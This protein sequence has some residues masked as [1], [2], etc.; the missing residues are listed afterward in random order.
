VI[1]IQDVHRNT[2]AQW[3]IRETVSA[4][5][6]TGQVSFLALE[7]AT[8]QIALQPY[9]DFPHPD[10]V[11]LAADYL[12]RENDI[13]GPIHAALTAQQ[14]LPPVLG[15]DDPTL[16]TAN[17]QAYR[18]SA[19]RLDQSRGQ[20]KKLQ[21]ELDERKKNVYSPAL[22]TF[23][24]S[25][26]DY[27]NGRIGLGPYVQSLMTATKA[28]APAAKTFLQALALERALDFH[29]V[30]I[31]RVRLVTVLTQRL[32]P[33]ETNALLADSLAYRAGRLGYADFYARLKNICRQADLK[34]SAYPAM[35]AYIRYVLLADGIDA[36]RLLNELNDLEKAAFTQLSRR[37]E[38]RILVNQSRQ[39]WLSQQLVNFS[40]TP[41]GWAEYET[42]PTADRNPQWASFESFYRAAHKRDEAM[43]HR[44]IAELQRSTHRSVA[45]LVTGGYHADGIAQ[46]LNRQGI[47]VVSFVPKI[48]KI[49]SQDG[50]T[51]LS[52]FTQAKTPLEKLFQGE[53][54]FLAQSPWKTS[55]RQ[56]LAPA[57]VVL[58]VGLVAS[59]SGFDF[60]TAYASLG[61][62]GVLSSVTIGDGTVVAA[63]ATVGGS[64]SVKVVGSLKA[65]R[66]V[67][68]STAAEKRERWMA[69]ALSTRERRVGARLAQ[70]AEV[71][72][73]GGGSGME[74]MGQAQKA[75]HTVQG[76]VK[77]L[78]SNLS[79]SGRS[80]ALQT[81]V[82]RD[83]SRWTSHFREFLEGLPRWITCHFD[84]VPV[85]TVPSM[86]YPMQALEGGI[87]RAWLKALL[88][89]EITDYRGLPSD[90]LDRLV[91]KVRER[92]DYIQDSEESEK[93][94]QSIR[95]RLMALPE[96]L[97][98]LIRADTVRLDG[99][100]IPRAQPLRNLVF[101]G[102][103]YRDH[104]VRAP[105][106]LSRSALHHMVSGLAEDLDSSVVPL[107]VGLETAWDVSMVG[108]DDNDREVK[109]E[110]AISLRSEIGPLARVQLA[111]RHRGD[112]RG[113]RPMA[114][115][116]ALRAIREAKQIVLGPANLTTL[117]GAL[118]PAGILEAMAEAKARGATVTWFLSP[119]QNRDTEGLTPAGVVEVLENSLST[120]GRPV[121]LG[122]FLL[123]W[124]ST[125]PLLLPTFLKRCSEKKRTISPRPPIPRKNGTKR[126]WSVVFG[127]NKPP[128]KFKWNWKIF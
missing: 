96:S 79:Q 91:L 30:E 34:L 53:K 100:M 114:D 29:Q 17:V 102:A 45:V 111:D 122:L 9:L 87:A 78:V 4:L 125:I 63:L 44:L 12:L 95:G 46:R 19:P 72:L 15:I 65:L 2:E 76:P 51:Y 61:G 8:E 109:G 88:S 106:L 26:A 103:L 120:S 10:A 82:F 77:A 25:V 69:R 16:Y 93:I 73:L 24:K 83:W 75:I 112:E 85:R 126:N 57:L 21:A 37:A 55:V 56:A 128:K 70:K 32:H 99:V 97:Q 66:T 113:Y 14:T 38:E 60:S 121:S 49:D 98:G 42:I 62:K 54:L 101:L 105:G 33:K 50:S 127:R 71:V 104:V 80:A 58:A 20:I 41:L 94:I 123:T 84:L 1:H 40:L 67:V 5:L 48:E 108:L 119:V 36:E 74:R 43:A 117:V 22:L 110:Q 35:D 89:E 31:E 7:G 59:V 39:A 107:G 90:W 64:I 6:G 81:I 47:T 52:V 116:E 28:E 11:R 92:E 86:G 115:P 23:D 27:R 18:N 13:S 68:W 118:A 3:N 124:S